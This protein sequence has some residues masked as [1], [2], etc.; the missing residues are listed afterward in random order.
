MTNEQFAE[1][2]WL[3]FPP[4]VRALRPMIEEA[5]HDASKTAN[6]QAEAFALALKGYTVDPDIMV[7][8]SRDPMTVIDMRIRNGYVWYPALGEERNYDLV[9]TITLTPEAYVALGAVGVS[10][11]P[12]DPATPTPRFIPCSLDPKD[13]PSFAQPTDAQPPVQIVPAKPDFHQPVGAGR[14]NT[15]P[16][17]SSPIGTVYAGPEGKFEKVQYVN[18]QKA[19]AGV[20][21]FFKSVFWE[22]L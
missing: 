1:M 3:H 6:V 20:F 17:D 22:A 9:P 15:L 19:P 5:S 18:G 16:G 8:Y 14:F 4:E 12:Y 13:W 21:A 10:M 11:R 7:G 2:F